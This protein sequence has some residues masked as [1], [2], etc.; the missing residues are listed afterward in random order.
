METQLRGTHVRLPQVQPAVCHAAV[1]EVQ[2]Q[3]GGGQQGDTAPTRCENISVSRLGVHTA[4]WLAPSSAAYTLKPD[5]CK[6]R[7]EATRR[8]VQVV[9]RAEQS[10]VL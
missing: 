8:S 9:I 3:H 1:G 2:R 6:S 4:P 5:F 7:V 10:G